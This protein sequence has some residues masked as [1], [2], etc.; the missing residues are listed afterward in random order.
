VYAGNPGLIL[1]SDP[2]RNA[3]NLGALPALLRNPERLG[4]APFPQTPVYPFQGGVRDSINIFHEDIQVPWADSLTLGVQRALGRNH[5]IEARYVGTRS[6]DGWTTYNYNEPNIV[7]NGFLDEFR[8]AQANLRANIAA[9]RGNT[10]AYTG[11]PGTSPLPI[12]LAHFSGIPMDLA[13]D[14]SLYTSSNF[15]NSRWYNPMAMF[16]PDPFANGNNA[17]A[18]GN[19]VNSGLFGVAAFRANMLRA[20]LPAN[21]WVANPDK[22]NANI[23]GNGGKTH[24][25]SMQFELRRRLHQGLQFNSSY[26]FGKAYGSNRFSF[27]TPRLMRRDTGSPGDLTHQLKANVVYDLPFG[28]GRRFASNAGAIMERIVG[29]WS[30]GV[31]ARVQSGRLVNL[32]NI[33]LVGMTAEDVEDLFD[34]RIAPNGRVYMWPD[35]I[36]NE[37]IKAWSTSATSASGYGSLGP[38]SGRYFAPANG[39]DCIET[40]PGFG[41]CG[42][43]DL[44]VTGPLFKQFDI[45]VSKRIRLF[46]NANLELRAEALNAFNHVN[47][48]PNDGIG[49]TDLTDW[50]V[51]GLTG[52][53]AA[54][55]IQL[56]GR[57]NW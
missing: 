56:I 30:L 52:T 22:L 14:P 3:N 48:V 35:A 24:Y 39:P 28:R 18:A 10:F 46:G 7:E 11:I 1:G 19:N 21:F 57:F 2:D 42:I 13:G 37:T 53:N 9:G 33:R 15:R 32:G 49:E 6:R 51:T 50:E 38:P 20:G 43:G 29:G 25:N 34:L 36:M 5:V 26:V 44:V 16:N 47:F 17:G 12:Y 55:V 8:L 4:P 27:R 40:A 54:R 41:D 23:V 45:A 31:N